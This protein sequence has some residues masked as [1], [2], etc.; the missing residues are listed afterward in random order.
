MKQV[1]LIGGILIVVVGLGVVYFFLQQEKGD[2]DDVSVA[3][4]EECRT[5]GYP[6]MESYPQRCRTPDGKT[7]AEDIGNE[8]EKAD[9]I[10]VVSPRPTQTISSPL[11]L[12]GEARGV[13]FFEASFPIKLL[14]GNG[15]EIAVAIAQAQGEW[16][17]EEFVPFLATLEFSMPDTEGGTLIFQKDNPSGLPEHADSLVMP[18]RF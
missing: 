13:W 15:K 10:R 7:F 9:L 3:N 8:L 2:I 18:I 4:F 17:T 6:I 12:E 14:D 11:V 16:M 1:F 5:A